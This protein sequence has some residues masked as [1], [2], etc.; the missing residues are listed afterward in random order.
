MAITLNSTSSG[1]SEGTGSPGTL[2]FEHVVNAGD[3]RILTVG[4]T[5]ETSGGVLPSVDTITYD[6]VGL[7]KIGLIEYKADKN[8]VELWYL[9]APNVGTANVVITLTGALATASGLLGGAITINGAT[10]QAPEASDTASGTSTT[11]SVAITTI[12]NNAWVIDAVATDS[13][14]ND[15]TVGAGQTERYEESNDCRGNGSTEPVETA[16]EI[17]MSWTLS[18]DTWG[19]CAASFE[20]EGGAPPPATGFMTT[21]TGYW[22]T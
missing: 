19:I 1:N 3:N 21:N 13:S 11:A 20:A 17:A 12:T 15:M 8:A 18:S 5:Y 6:G 2:T 7:T 14:S 4:V 16:G 22:G 9:L 10:Q